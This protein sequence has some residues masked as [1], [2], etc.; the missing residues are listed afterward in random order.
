MPRNLNTNNPL[1]RTNAGLEDNPNYTESDRIKPLDEVKID[2]K[3]VDF[4]TSLVDHARH[5]LGPNSPI[6]FNQKNT[7]AIAGVLAALGKGFSTQGG[8][9]DVLGTYV[10]QDIERSKQS[11]AIGAYED[12]IKAK[13]SGDEVSQKTI[14]DLQGN[15]ELLQ[16]AIQYVIEKEREFKNNRVYNKFAN[17]INR[18]QSVEDLESLNTD[19]INSL[20]PELQN[21]IYD[22]IEQR[23]DFLIQRDSRDQSN[24]AVTQMQMADY[25]TLKEIDFNNFD[26]ISS[27]D[28]N[29]LIKYQQELIKDKREDLLQKEG[30]QAMQ[31]FAEDKKFDMDKYKVL[32]YKDLMA[33]KKGEFELDTERIADTEAIK[34]KY[35]LESK[36]SDLALKTLADAGSKLDLKTFDKMLNKAEG[37]AEEQGVSPQTIMQSMLFSNLGVQMGS[38]VERV[39]GAASVLLKDFIRKGYDEETAKEMV[40]DVSRTSGLFNDDFNK[41]M[42]KAGIDINTDTDYED[43]ETKTEAKNPDVIKFNIDG[44]DIKIKTEGLNQSQIDLLSKPPGDLTEEENKERVRII[45]NN[46]EY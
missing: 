21:E 6:N 19:Y 16:K 2:T 23:K 9:G 37:I 14:Q 41:A 42:K 34:A 3:P 13:L 1:L 12:Y 7:E 28:R 43:T 15:P 39:R 45:T 46:T 36:A 35:Q 25:E 24:Q 38:D 10:M 27:D 33:I 40:V 4:K 26:K 5:N 31:D 32:T 30:I 22:A 17:L 20:S 8:P 44:S 29:E 11:R 18:A